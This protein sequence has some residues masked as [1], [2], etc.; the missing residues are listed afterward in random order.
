[1]LMQWMAFQFAKLGLAKK[2]KKKHCTTAAMVAEKLLFAT[3]MARLYF[4]STSCCLSHQ[5]CAFLSK[6]QKFVKPH[7]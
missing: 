6:I 4:W 5:S 7:L 3:I 2:K 1:M